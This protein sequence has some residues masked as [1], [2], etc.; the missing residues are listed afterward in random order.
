M[1]PKAEA[2]HVTDVDLGK[3]IGT[4]KHI[5]DKTDNFG[6]RD[7]IYASVITD[8]AASGAKLTARWTFNNGAR[9]I[10]TDTATISPAGGTT[11]T[12]FHITKA[13]PWPKGKYRLEVLLN[14]APVQKKDFEV[15]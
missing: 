9:V 10:K 5:A 2:L 1:A 13:T 7:T 11:A 4:V 3:H 8:G 12:E 15:K 14:G 6:V